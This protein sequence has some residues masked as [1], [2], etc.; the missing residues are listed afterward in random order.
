MLRLSSSLTGVERERLLDGALTSAREEK[1]GFARAFAASE[2]AAIDSARLSPALDVL[3]EGG[4][5]NA[6]AGALSELI[7]RLGD[8]AASTAI[9][10]LRRLDDPWAEARLLST[11][12]PKLGSCAAAAGFAH[13]S[14]FSSGVSRA[15]IAAALVP[16]LP[17]DLRDRAEKLLDGID[18]DYA[19]LDLLAPTVE[20]WPS[21]FTQAR[22]RTAA[23]RISA[24]SGDDFM[25]EWLVRMAPHWPTDAWPEFLSAIDRIG[26][27]AARA[28]VL[29]EL[30]RRRD[31]AEIPDAIAAAMDAL[32]DDFCR[33]VAFGHLAIRFGDE[34]LLTEVL[35][36]AACCGGAAARIEALA[37]MADLAESIPD[38]LLDELLAYWVRE[39][40]PLATAL[41]TIG[42]LLTPLH[43]V[44]VLEM[45]R[46]PPA[47]LTPELL[48]ELLFALAQRLAEADIAQVIAIAARRCSERR[49]T[50]LLVDLAEI[51]DSDVGA[52]AA[53]EL[54]LK[55][56]SPTYRADVLC[57]VV[58]RL[59]GADRER[60]L[61][62]LRSI[63]DRAER[64]R[65]LLSVRSA[66]VGAIQDLPCDDAPASHKN[67]K[68]QANAK[69]ARD[70]EAILQSLLDDAMARS[71]ESSP[72]PARRFRMNG[73]SRRKGATLTEQLK[74]LKC[75]A[76]RY[77]A[78]LKQLHTLSQSE[79]EA[80]IVEL[81]RQ[82]T[83]VHHAELLGDIVE[84]MPERQR[85]RLLMSALSVGDQAA[86]RRALQLVT[87]HIVGASKLALHGHWCDFL[88]QTRRED[89]PELFSALKTMAP[90]LTALGGEISVIEAIE[91]IDEIGKSWP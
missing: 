72:A 91:A 5:T 78:T 2:V 69:S 16:R 25:A 80:L 9:S 15:R 56:K 50:G 86:K 53:L 90:L 42:H 37:T 24:L 41:L 40:R 46:D 51:F 30:L 68:S 22:A 33:S 63:E 3:Y 20:R 11:V 32:S 73:E 10:T 19:W 48:D 88:E 67:L 38:A 6:K 54:A 44:R 7:P 39:T 55:M 35:Q 12:A 81:P 29:N 28:E 4:D 14:S 58:D 59:N 1:H 79:L 74:G 57:S 62:S 83:E 85:E 36:R 31:P 77:L 34:A 43:A 76:D 75:E 89:R 18:P 21:T 87:P 13:V 26:G 71:S 65:R 70:T 52:P 45:L 66:A 27:P 49:L 84:R 64:E 60:A 82:F 47:S 61:T 23:F 8:E 17:D